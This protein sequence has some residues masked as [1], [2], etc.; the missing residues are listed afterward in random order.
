MAAET[1]VSYAAERP[2]AFV[3]AVIAIALTLLILPLMESVGDV[4]AAGENT[5]SWFEDH[6]GQLVS[7]VLSFVLIA[8]FWMIHHQL[9]TGVHRVTSPLLWLLGAWMLTIVWLPV[10]TAI[11]GHMA[12]SDL[13]ARGVYIG[14]LTCTAILMLVVRL[15]LRARPEL[16]SIGRADFVAGISLDLS[17]VFLFLFALLLTIVFEALGYWAL[18]VTVFSGLVQRLLVRALRRSV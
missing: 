18:V 13:L 5:L 4:A 16:H 6:R 12:D 8:M 2:K 1:T 17:L 9:F 15:Y 11:A 10:A 3:D 14:S 7:F